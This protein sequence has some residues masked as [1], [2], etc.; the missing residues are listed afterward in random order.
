MEQ[1][2]RALYILTAGRLP[3]WQE[4]EHWRRVMNGSRTLCAVLMVLLTL[5]FGYDA[6]VTAASSGH[7]PQVLTTM[8]VV[9]AAGFTIIFFLAR[10]SHL[11]RSDMQTRW[12][13]EQADKK[14]LEAGHTVALYGDRAVRTDLRGA[15]TMEYDRM[16]ACVET[17]YGFR[18]TAGS[19]SILIRSDDLTAEEV[20]RIRLHLQQRLPAGLYRKKGDAVPRLRESLPIP[21][22]QNDDEIL[23]R[24]ALTLRQPWLNSRRQRQINTVI[25]GFVI[26]A[27]AIYGTALASQ[28]YIIG[29]YFLDLLLFCGGCILGS[30]LLIRALC[31][32]GK[33]KTPLSLAFTRDGL[34]GFSGGCSFF[35]VWERIRLKEEKKG[36]RAVFADGDHLLIPW[37]NMEQPDAVKQLIQTR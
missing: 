19:L 22:F 36:V 25:R 23:S 17:M 13:D 26:P 11:V 12:Y 2:D 18:L 20:Y 28:V 27:M 37:N 21:R 10:Q 32:F 6:V 9:L 8:I 24:A 30:V 14:R 15:V 16:T 5:F 34:A 7:W 33:K 1:T 35:T 3:S 29:E 4:R 31:A